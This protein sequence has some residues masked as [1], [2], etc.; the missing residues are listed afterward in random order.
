[1]HLDDTWSRESKDIKWE[2]MDMKTLEKTF[3][4]KR[5]MMYPKTKRILALFKVPDKKLG[6]TP[7]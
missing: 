1:M 5:E 7:Q 4:K 2:E 6:E 3:D